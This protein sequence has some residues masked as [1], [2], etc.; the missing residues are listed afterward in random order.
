MNLDEKITKLCEEGNELENTKKYDLAIEK[1]Q[2]AL[3]IVEDNKL[4]YDIGWF[5]IAIGE[6]YFKKQD[7]ENALKYYEMA[8]KQQKYINSWFTNYRIANILR[9]SEKLLEAREKYILSL[10]Y[11]METEKNEDKIQDYIKNSFEVLGQFYVNEERLSKTIE[12]KMSKYLN[13]K[14][15]KFKKLKYLKT[16]ELDK[17]VFYMGV[18]K[19]GL[20]D[21]NK[22][23]VFDGKNFVLN[24]LYNDKTE[25]EDIIS[26]FNLNGEQKI[27]I[28]SLDNI[29]GKEY[30]FA[31]YKS[32]SKIPDDNNVVEY[33]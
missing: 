19:N 15:E 27:R 14:N 28:V 23:I 25:K 22:L 7:L 2:E 3:K 9:D 1:F 5:Y 10:K 17:K 33:K 24:N 16:I 26:L 13:E 32:G 6:Q 29:K 20:F 4:E 8:N 18:Y 11:I 31:E 30:E 21:K 12:E